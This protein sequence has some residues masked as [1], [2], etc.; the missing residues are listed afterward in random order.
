MHEPFFF[1]CLLMNLAVQFKE[2]LIFGDITWERCISLY[3]SHEHNGLLAVAVLVGDKE[4]KK[5]QKFTYMAVFLVVVG[6][7]IHVTCLRS[8]KFV[9]PRKIDY[10][11]SRLILF[12]FHFNTIF[13]ISYYFHTIFISLRNNDNNSSFYLFSVCCMLASS[14]SFHSNFPL[15]LHNCFILSLLKIET[16]EFVQLPSETSV[17]FFW[18]WLV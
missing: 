3:F 13:T 12:S 5:S 2:Y 18:H 16:E 17:I 11:S 15:N 9:W 14:Q 7:R 1:F 6:G 4:H 8:H 10:P